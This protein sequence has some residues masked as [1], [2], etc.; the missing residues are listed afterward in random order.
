M[1][2]YMCLYVN[3]YVYV[4]YTHT[5]THLSK[6]DCIS[7]NWPLRSAKYCSLASVCSFARANAR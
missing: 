1:H 2:R 4:N 7:S 5:H 3:V 6:E